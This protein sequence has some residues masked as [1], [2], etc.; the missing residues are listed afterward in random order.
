[1]C[2][3]ILIKAL[4]KTICTPGLMVVSLLIIC[5]IIPACS[6]ATRYEPSPD[7]IITLLL[8]FPPVPVP[9]VTPGN[10]STIE[11]E[12]AIGMG[13]GWVDIETHEFRQFISH[14]QN[15]KAQSLE[16]KRGYRWISDSVYVTPTELRA[17]IDKEVQF[18]MDYTLSEGIPSHWYPTR[19]WFTPSLSDGEMQHFTTTMN[20]STG[21]EG[22][23]LEIDSVFGHFAAFDSTNGGGWVRWNSTG[24]FMNGHGANWDAFGNITIRYWMNSGL[25]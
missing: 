21:K 19:G 23:S 24:G 15:T 25:L 10:K 6:R 1:M 14:V 3:T 18:E 20:W 5:L 2:D 13:Q 22:Y 8:E 12:T 16:G 7:E 17:W 4:K 9:P 11:L